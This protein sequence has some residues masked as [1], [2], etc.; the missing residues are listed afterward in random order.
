MTHQNVNQLTGHDF[1]QARENIGITLKAVYDRLGINRNKLSQFEQEKGTLRANEK[2]ELKRFYEERGHDFGE[3]EPID[4]NNLKAEYGA[5]KME[6]TESIDAL[7]PNETGEALISYIDSVHD[8][9]TV[10]G[11]L[12]DLIHQ[13]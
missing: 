10:N 9:L 7:M 13:K 2:R 8:E 12:D 1:F 4:G 11:Y 5:N 3:P 6:V